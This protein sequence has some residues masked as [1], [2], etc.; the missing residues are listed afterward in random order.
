M[1]KKNTKTILLIIII[2]V[3]LI[4]G[5][6]ATVLLL[7]K[8]KED[9]KD[10][11]TTTTSTT[12]NTTKTTTSTTTTT[13]K[14]KYITVTFSTGEGSKVDPITLK[15]TDNA[16]ILEKLPE[17]PTREEFRFRAW[18][19]KHGKAI[20]AGAKLVCEDI[21]LYAGWEFDGPMTIQTN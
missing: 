19:D 10:N 6:V 9:N 2:V 7:N 8:N 21:T 4:W 3:L 16:V 13:G 17:N 1:E 11:T 14:D 5:V 12:T 15:C 20:L 18:E